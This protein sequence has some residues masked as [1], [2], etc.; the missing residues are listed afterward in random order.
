MSAQHGE[1]DVSTADAFDAVPIYDNTQSPADLENI[2]TQPLAVRTSSDRASAEMS[3]PL[4]SESQQSHPA[5]TRPASASSAA[6]PTPASSQEI[7]DQIAPVSS[8]SVVPSAT[9]TPSNLPTSRPAAIPE[10]IVTLADVAMSRRPSSSRYRA[11]LP[12]LPSTSDEEQR[13]LQPQTTEQQPGQASDELANGQFSP[14]SPPLPPQPPTRAATD[15]IQRS[16]IQSSSSSVQ[17]EEQQLLSQ[18]VTSPPP[19]PP[20]PPTPPAPP[21]PPA[22]PPAPPPSGHS[23][24]QQQQSRQLQ[25]F[26]LPRWQPD[27]E[28]TYCPICSQQFSIFVRKH[29]CRKCGR[30]VCNS[31]SPH[32]I[33]IPYPYI[34]QPPGAQPYQ[35]QAAQF[36]P[37]GDVSRLG[38]GERVRLC[39]PCVPD[40]NT[41]PPAS[42]PRAAAADALASVSGASSR[43][44]SRSFSSARGG[45]NQ[46][47]SALVS[48]TAAFGQTFFRS[49]TT[50]ANGTWAES[51]TAPASAAPA[52]QAQARHHR[53]SLQ[54]PNSTQGL[55]MA[56]REAYT[57]PEMQANAHL[58]GSSASGSTGQH[59][60][61]H[62]S[63]S[64]HTPAPPIAEEDECPV[65]R[66][67]L[68]RRELANFETLREAHITQCIVTHS[69]YMGGSSPN[70]LS[71][72]IPSTS[73]PTT[74]GEASSAAAL[75]P[76]T[77]APAPPLRRTGMFPYRA[78]EKDCVDDAECTIC[79]EEFEVGV[80][81]ARLE[82]FC[83]FHEQCILAW[84]V[85]H[86]GCCPVHQ[87]DSF[88]Y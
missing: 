61:H 57:R 58:H 70:T 43:Q 60:R 35:L 55:G 23:Y 84:F 65:C 37:V 68:P 75:G 79:L 31:C 46:L 36:G 69:Q 74:P 38:G 82:C 76:P 86:P 88:G 45:S 62:H 5:D 44:Y 20:T 29:H 4:A 22:S 19:A 33:T 77:G 7:S 8:S 48:P 54:F 13:Q 3:S 27:S 30:V 16:Q 71:S 6:L 40:P 87:H 26:A 12:P 41:A 21:A 11:P 32:R 83:R 34:V 18:T 1:G 51:S 47:N 63:R 25:E 14:S 9:D 49:V 53:H 39:N 64:H 80:G 15:G 10:P 50:P 73:L 56:L 17:L 72:P 66:R 78:T 81:M 85:K 24:P 59:R 67:E 2:D 52:N 28:V 42:S